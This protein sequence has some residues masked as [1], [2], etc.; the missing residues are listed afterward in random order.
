MGRC[1]K[2]LASP[3]NF[4]AMGVQCGKG[5]PFITRVQITRPSSTNTDSIHPYPGTFPFK[6]PTMCTTLI[7]LPLLLRT[8]QILLPLQ[9]H[10]LYRLKRWGWFEAR[11]PSRWSKRSPL[12]VPILMGWSPNLI[13]HDRQSVF[14]IHQ[15]S[16]WS[17]G[18]H[19]QLKIPRISDPHH[20]S[21]IL[22]SGHLMANF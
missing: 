14:Q 4:S 21:S 2:L 11:H 18:L 6:S 22:F 5:T 7:F 13:P 12:P 16:P 15:R 19:S 17:K 1:R 10:R 8:N 3:Q 9:E 20:C